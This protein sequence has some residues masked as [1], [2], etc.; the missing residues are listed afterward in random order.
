MEDNSMNN[1]FV[2]L[3]EKQM[4]VDER[5]QKRDALYTAHSSMVNEVL[6]ELISAYRPGLWKKGCDASRSFCKRVGW[7]AGPELSFWTSYDEHHH[8][9]R[10]IDIVL[11]V[12]AACRPTGFKVIHHNNNHKCVMVGFSRDELVRG[13]LKVF[14]CESPI[15]SHFQQE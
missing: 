2:V 10:C 8:I 5:K 13:I 12:D 7:F 3:K 11:E 14:D 15:Y 9:A 6:D 1:P 4:Y